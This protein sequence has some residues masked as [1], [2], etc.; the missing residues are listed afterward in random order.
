MRNR[1]TNGLHYSHTRKPVRDHKHDDGTGHL[2]PV[3]GP[4]RWC[5]GPWR[6][7][8]INVNKDT[9]MHWNEIHVP[10]TFGPPTSTMELDR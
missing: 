3:N 6:V 7:I 9:V 4:C 1:R 5:D 8:T 10:W 2:C